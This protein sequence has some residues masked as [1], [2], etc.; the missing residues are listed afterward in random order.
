MELFG[1]RRTS[2]RN[3][4]ENG[5]ALITTLLILLLVSTMIVGI[6]WLVMGD[7]KLGGNMN[8][9]QLAYYGAEAGMEELTAS[10]TNA[11]DANYSLDATAINGL[12]TNPGPPTNIPQVEYL[13]PGNATNGSGYVIQFT[14]STANPNL[15]STSWGTIPTGAQYAGL[16]GLMTPYT[17][18][19]T[20]HTLAGS[21]VKLEREVQT[22]GIPIFQFGMFSQTDLSFF[23]GPDFNFGGRVHSNGNLWL[24]EGGGTLTLSGTTTA[25]GNIITSNLENG[26]PTSSNYGTAVDITTGSGTANLMSQSPN[27]SVANPPPASWFG[28]VNAY[29]SA[30]G[31]MASS[32]YANNV[33]VGGMGVQPLNIAIATPAIGGQSIDLIRR[34]VAGESTSNAAKY[35]ERDYSQVSLRILLS[36]YGSDG[37]CAT[38]DISSTSSVALPGLATNGTG[39]TVTPVDLATLSWD[40]SNTTGNTNNNSNPPPYKNAPPGLTSS[41]VGVTIF[42]LPVSYAQAA[43]YSS[44][45][46]YWVKSEYPTITGCLKID[47]Q[48][49]SSPPTWTD[50]TWDILNYGYTG[51]NI[52]PQIGG[53]LVPSWSSPRS[54]PVGAEPSLST[55]SSNGTSLHNAQVDG[56]GPTQNTSVVTVG[57]N[58]PSPSAIIRLARLRDNP[59]TALGGTGTNRNNYC[60][61]NPSS[62]GSGTWYTSGKSDTATCT[63]AGSTPNCPSQY[64]T[65]Y[66][67]NVLYDTREALLQ[68]PSSPMG[69]GVN[70]KLPVAGAMYY[71]ELD[72]ANLA[73]WFTNDATG[74]TAF[75]GTGTQT[76]NG[77]GYSVYFSDRRGEQLDDQNPPAS[78]SPSGAAALT[79]GFGWEDNVNFVNNVSA[80]NGCPNGQLDQGEDVESDYNNGVSENT[81]NT[82]KTYGNI[83]NPPVGSA[84]TML[85]PVNISGTITGTQLGTVSALT[86]SIL[87]NNPNCTTQGKN[88]PLAVASQ[89]QDLR[90]NPPIFFR[91]A[92]KVTDGSTINGT[93]WG[94]C[95]SVPCGLTI[96]SENPLYLQ[97][98]YNNPGLNTNFSG[99]GVGA[100]IISDSFTFL[101]DDWNDVNSF[102]WPYLSVTNSDGRNVSHSVTY[103][104]AVAAGKGIPFKNTNG[105]IYQ[106][107]GTDG[108][109]H[110]FLRQLEDWSGQTL[111]YE[112]S[113]VS[114]WYSHQGV[115]IYKCCNNVYNPPSRGYQFD[116][117]F[118]TP[119]DLPPLTPMLRVVNT[120]GATQV[121]LPTE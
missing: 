20:A 26:W 56:S 105:T 51:R 113:I 36:D 57:C 35:S 67:P 15:P 27:E 112:G 13:A 98:D 17:L 55:L 46:G 116:N 2:V 64:G 44:S 32:V 84:P 107:F 110:N 87:A 120:V 94:T 8:D 73:S 4:R 75:N 79:G 99:T 86:A 23:A 47:M 60:G 97:G 21:E 119:N 22:V 71:V 106:D 7:Q 96:V 43:S 30:F 78:V 74:K 69:S 25:A 93:G 85:W 48:T 82:L 34:P 62:G 54:S 58:D 40:T 61:N 80:T 50:V 59:S 68:D 92:L 89:P 88:W 28:S 12:M 45:D 9:R 63:T 77:T 31:T 1:K 81:T 14:P 91:R 115:G 11:F 121:I 49:D 42:P 65:D 72:V 111:Y 18:T 38:S 52:N 104:L 108:G 24:T 102:A 103:R 16:V 10:L 101:S 70:N 114:L 3:R 6:G 37:T 83:L 33:Q 39:N 41:Q 109:A 29:N 5:I 118:L 90:E 19:V 100:S 53:T 117:N 66:W 95:N 76:A